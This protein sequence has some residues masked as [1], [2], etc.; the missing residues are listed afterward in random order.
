MLRDALIGIALLINSPP[1]YYPAHTLLA[2]LPNLPSLHTHIH[3]PHP[4]VND[5][6]VVPVISL[7]NN[8]VSWVDFPLKHG[9]EDIRL[10]LWFQR[11]EQEDCFHHRLQTHSLRISLGVDQLRGTD[12]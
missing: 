11:F 12:Y 2:Y 7:V 1:L 10:L 5:I 3:Q 8:V 4:L 6:E 9:I